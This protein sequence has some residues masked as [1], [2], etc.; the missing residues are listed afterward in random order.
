[1][2]CIGEPKA[3][4]QD[5]ATPLMGVRSAFVCAPQMVNFPLFPLPISGHLLGGKGRLAARNARLPT[6]PDSCGRSI[7][8]RTREA[9]FWLVSRSVAD[10]FPRILTR[11]GIP[12]R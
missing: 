5:R 8:W 6:Y 1:M 7:I 2:V 11:S 4:V 9:V 10:S 12:T 3:Q